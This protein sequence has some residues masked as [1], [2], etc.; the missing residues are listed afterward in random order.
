MALKAPLTFVVI[1]LAVILCAVIGAALWGIWKGIPRLLDWIDKQNAAAREHQKSLIADVRT[2]ASADVKRA[3]DAVSGAHKEIGLKVEAVHADV[4]RLMVKVGA[5]VVVIFLAS[6]A[7]Q[8]TMVLLATYTCSPPCSGNT[9]CCAQDTCCGSALIGGRS[10]YVYD[11][12]SEG[13]YVGEWL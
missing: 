11:F 3:D 1:L 5:T 13:H 7:F 6:L 8:K 9:F 2:D 4:R 10:A 12:R